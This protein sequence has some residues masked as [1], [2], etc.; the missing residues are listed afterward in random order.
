MTDEVKEAAK[1][2]VGTI[3]VDHANIAD[4]LVDHYFDLG[5]LS[6]DMSDEDVFTRTGLLT[7]GLVEGLRVLSGVYDG[8]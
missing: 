6:E 4:T 5:V 8:T 2:L 3:S 1:L 7:Y